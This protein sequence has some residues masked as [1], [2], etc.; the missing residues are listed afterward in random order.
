MTP[1]FSINAFNEVSVHVRD[2]LRYMF[3]VCLLYWF[4]KVPLEL[5]NAC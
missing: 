2:C 5:V 1:H 4:R 3:N